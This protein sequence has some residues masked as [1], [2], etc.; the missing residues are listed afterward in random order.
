MFGITVKSTKCVKYLHMVLAITVKS[1]NGVKYL[2][3][4][5]A[6]NM[7][8]KSMGTSIIRMLNVQFW[9]RKKCTLRVR[10]GKCYATVAFNHIFT[11]QP[12]I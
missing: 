12:F 1:T 5:L 7:Y 10:K 8:G 2:C 11:S 4:K 9:C 6:Y 3:M